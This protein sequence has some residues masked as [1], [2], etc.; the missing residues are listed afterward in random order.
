[1]TDYTVHRL[2]IGEYIPGVIQSI[3]S[4]P[5]SSSIAV[6]REDGQIEILADSRSKW[7][8]QA[9]VAGLVEK[10]GSFQLRSLVWSHCDLSSN[11]LFGIS[12][13]GFIFEVLFL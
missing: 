10:E 1:M 12:L 3:A 2:R 8:C 4:D 5:F 11:R 13:R 7:V 9:V 6:G